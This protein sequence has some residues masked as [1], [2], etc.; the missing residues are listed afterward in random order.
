MSDR[1]VSKAARFASGA[2]FVLLAAVAVAAPSLAA[3]PVD[4]GTAVLHGLTHTEYFP[5]DICGPRASTV[6]FTIRTQVLHWTE[7]DSTYNVQFTETGEYHVDFIDPALEDQNSQFT[8]SV[9]HVLTPG[10]TEVFNLTF[11]DFPTGIKIWE[12]IHATFANG[13]LV[14]ERELQK[15]TGC[16]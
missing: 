9:H 4:R 3:P 14:V 8:E 16:P 2:L 7:D 11:H 13:E 10:G 5:D 12:R 6:T 15:V 1:T